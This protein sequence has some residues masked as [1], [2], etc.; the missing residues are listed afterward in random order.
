[1]PAADRHLRPWAWAPPSLTESTLSFL[2][3][4]VKHPLASW[5]NDHQRC[6]HRLRYDATT[7]S[8][9]SPSVSACCLTVLGFNF[10]G[11]GLRDAYD[12]KMQTLIGRR[13]DTMAKNKRSAYLSAKES[14]RISQI[15]RRVTDRS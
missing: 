12:P 10:V 1:M 6:Q 2:G 11:D 4:G 13:N 5:G 15:N 3:L 8:S 14:R 7:C 9:G